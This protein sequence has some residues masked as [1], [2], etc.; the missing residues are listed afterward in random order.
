MSARISWHLQLVV[1]D[2]KLDDARA[3]MD[4]TLEATAQETGAWDY[5]WFIS[6]ADQTCHICER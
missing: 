2:G 3:S 6:P 1:Q 4:E 5:E